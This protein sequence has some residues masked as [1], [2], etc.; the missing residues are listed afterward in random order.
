MEVEV[1]TPEDFMGEVIG[2]LNQR[3][4]R[5]LGMDSRGRWQVVRATV[6]LAELHKYAA[7]VRSLTQGK[8]THTR[9]LQG[10]DPVPPHVAE[11]VIAEAEQ[12]REAALAAR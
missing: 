11:K 1:R 6:P 5:I 9:T 8:G 2:D 12:E 4:G 10:Y 7:A 3:R